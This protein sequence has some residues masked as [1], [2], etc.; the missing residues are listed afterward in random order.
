MKLANRILTVATVLCVA[1]ANAGV[2][3]VV[4]VRQH[5]TCGNACDAS[6]PGGKDHSGSHHEPSTCSFCIQFAS[7]KAVSPHFAEHIT[8]T[9]DPA[10]ELVSFRTFLLPS[11]SLSSL[12][13]RA[14]PLFC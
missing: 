14:P 10:E 3:H 8:C 1:L 6:P 12:P 5:S 9:A 4:H 13:A 11:V 2:L 7:G